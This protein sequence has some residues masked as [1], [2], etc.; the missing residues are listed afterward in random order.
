MINI[1]LDCWTD[2]PCSSHCQADITQALELG[3]ELENFPSCKELVIPAGTKDYTVKIRLY[4]TVDRL[5]ELSVHIK[6]GIG[7][8]LKVGSPD[9]CSVL[10]WASSMQRSDFCIFLFL[11][12]EK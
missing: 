6:A 12:L 1:F 7:G 10:S 3:V 2:I 9:G 8:S 5:L 4:D 11:I